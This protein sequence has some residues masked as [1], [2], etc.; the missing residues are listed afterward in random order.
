MKQSNL[1]KNIPAE[2]AEE[3]TEL[4]SSMSGVRIERIISRGQSSPDEGWYDQPDPEWVVLL[5]GGAVLRFEEDDRCLE[6][7]PGDWIEIPARCRHRV[8]STSEDEDSIWLAVHGV[9]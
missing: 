8:E 7:T 1:F 9:G 4:L 2:L 5:S 3:Q 6:L